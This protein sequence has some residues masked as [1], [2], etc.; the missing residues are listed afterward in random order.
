M[1]RF[2]YIFIVMLAGWPAA[3]TS[4]GDKPYQGDLQTLLVRVSYPEPWSE[5]LRSGVEV[6]AQEV[7]SGILY[8]SQTDETGRAEFRMANGIYR[9]SVSDRA[10]AS[11]VF[12][13]S[14]DRVQVI[15]RKREL[16]LALTY[17]RT[18]DLVIK[19]IY[20]A[21]CPKLP[22]QGTFN[23]DQYVILHNNGAETYYLDGLCFGCADPYNSNSGNNVWVT[24]DPVTGETIFPGY[25]P[26]I[27]AIWQFGGSGTDFPLP[28]GGDAVISINGARD[29][30]AQ[31]PMSVNL[32]QPDYF[33]LY[34][35]MLF[36]NAS[37]HPTPGDRIQQSHILKV[38]IKLGIAKAY[39]Y[40]QNSPA[41]VIF[42]SFGTTIE[43]FLSD[44][45]HVVQKPGSVSDKCAL[46]PE[47]WI[48]DGA[49]IFT[50]PSDPVKRLSPEVDAGFS[51]LSQTKMGHTIHRKLDEEATAE[52][53]Y[54]IYQDT[55]NSS[56]DFYERETQSLRKSL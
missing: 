24:K 32:N 30:A 50:T 25:V 2:F 41:T 16:T 3:C 44:P 42:R 27:Q 38:A 31:F 9:I 28:P 5:F 18:S 20:C 45:A 40:S 17:S 52:K 19:E 55:N 22:E 29:H 36:P 13:G 34:D 10:S 53:G 54:D 1:K 48:L 4:F 14:A 43:E 8:R 56:N 51:V 7:S 21:G 11:A 15:G 49:E 26:V 46:I 35:E 37:Y 6:E 33:V 39:T 47:E 23:Y 12:N